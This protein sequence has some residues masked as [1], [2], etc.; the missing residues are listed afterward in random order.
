MPA[1]LLRL[2]ELGCEDLVCLL[3]VHERAGIGVAG[4]P[5]AAAA[6]GLAFRAHPMQSGGRIPAPAEL[7][8]IVASVVAAV[9]E[10]RT[11]VVHCAGGLG[12]SG[13]IAG[14]ALRS[15]GWEADA[16]LRALVAA[17][18]SRCPETEGQREAIRRFG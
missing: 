13:L 10:G 3:P 18:G 15:M 4:L 11:V 6:A 17:R 7:T 16:A 2:Q 5:A 9:R 8:A 12:R 1:D 14:C